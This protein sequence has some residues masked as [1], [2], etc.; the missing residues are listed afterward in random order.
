MNGASERRLRICQTV[1]VA[2]DVAH[3]RLL[4]CNGDNVSGGGAERS[5]SGAAVGARAVGCVGVRRV[6]CGRAAR[7]V[8]PDARGAQ[9]AGLRLRGERVWLTT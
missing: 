2:G 9:G 1:F 5:G 3:R 8:Y 6:V 7:R 4:Q